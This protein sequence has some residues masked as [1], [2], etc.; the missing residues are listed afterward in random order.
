MVAKLSESIRLA[1]AVSD[2]GEGLRREGC[3]G[4]MRG[5]GAWRAT[6][7]T[8]SMLSYGD[9]EGKREIFFQSFHERA[10][11]LC[12]VVQPGNALDF[13][14]RNSRGEFYPCLPP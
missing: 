8:G 3:K 2:K 9:K 14:E 1:P 5:K 11:A 13:A 4:S 6:R 12:I 7:I 10:P